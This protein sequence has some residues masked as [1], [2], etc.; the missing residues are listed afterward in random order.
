M[1]PDHRTTNSEMKI[2]ILY[3]IQISVFWL[4]CLYLSHRKKRNGHTWHYPIFL[5]FFGRWVTQQLNVSFRTLPYEKERFEK[6]ASA[7][8][9]SKRNEAAGKLER[10]FDLYRCSI[11]IC[12]V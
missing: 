4:V 1:V 8:M 11:K 12:M 6:T 10:V 5:S 7:T 9:G 3:S 2:C